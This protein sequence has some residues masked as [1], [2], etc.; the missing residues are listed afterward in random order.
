M[1]GSMYRTIET[2]V[3]NAFEPTHL[4][5]TDEIAKH[6]FRTGAATGAVAGLVAITPAAGFVEPWAASLAGWSEAER[7][8]LVDVHLPDLRVAHRRFV[9]HHDA[10]AVAGRTEAKQLLEF[11]HLVDKYSREPGTPLEDAVRE[12][13]AR[14]TGVFAM[15]IVSRRDP[16]K[17][18]TARLG[19]PVVVGLGENEYF[20]ASDTIF[21][22]RIITDEIIGASSFRILACLEP[23]LVVIRAGRQ[24]NPVVRQRSC[25]V[26]ESGVDSRSL[27]RNIVEPH[28]VGEPGTGRT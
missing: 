27:A 15:A 13:I 12:A 16:R 23:D 4:E 1:N 28:T 6:W 3:T 2:K 5:V 24:P 7:M 10:I 18:V 19:P 22:A 20:V 25:L 17:V 8:H 11:A 9:D 26:V 21:L 14:L